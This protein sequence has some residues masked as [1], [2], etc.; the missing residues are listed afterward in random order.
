[1]EPL[2]QK[3]MGVNS[4]VYIIE[5][6]DVRADPNAGNI[7]F[8][9]AYFDLLDQKYKSA[10]KWAQFDPIPIGIK[11]ILAH[12]Y[13]H[14]FQFRMFKKKNVP[15]TTSTPIDELQADILASYF[16][17]S[18]LD[19]QFANLP[20]PE[21][22]KRVMDL[23]GGA[24]MVVSQLGD[25]YFN[26]KNHHGNPMTRHDCMHYGFAAGW[27]NQFGLPTEAMTT[28]EDLIYD[29]SRK[30][31]TESFNNQRNSPNFRGRN[32]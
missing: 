1:M 4:K 12:E 15:L 8:G 27:V 17:G 32:F 24:M 11:L 30:F 5:E 14:Q 31:A 26:D 29:W 3:G 16:I 21:K 10:I 13:A 25:F 6:E 19:A 2:L 23:S 7:Y 9:K 18:Y 20:T 22:I 28:R